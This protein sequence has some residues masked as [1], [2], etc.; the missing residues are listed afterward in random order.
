M[1]GKLAQCPALFQE[2]LQQASLT[3]HP[4]CTQ[5]EDP[6]SAHVLKHF[7]GQRCDSTH[8]QP[9]HNDE[10]REFKSCTCRKKVKND[11]RFFFTY[12]R[13]TNSS[14]N[15]Q[16]RHKLGSTRCFVQLA[17]SPTSICLTAR[18]MHGMPTKNLSYQSLHSCRVT[19]E[20]RRKRYKVAGRT[21]GDPSDTTM[22]MRRGSNRYRTVMFCFPFTANSGQYAETLSLKFNFL[23]K[24]WTQGM[25]LK[26]TFN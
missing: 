24:E 8:E 23:R 10:I 3:F 5:E 22:E 7:E 2:L 19:A 1:H 6:S 9:S 17:T 15:S 14:K 18:T 16:R 25:T 11:F 12:K 21:S 26:Q 4:S 13:R 20:V